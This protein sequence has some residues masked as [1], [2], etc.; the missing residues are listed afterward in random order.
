MIIFTFI[1]LAFWLWPVAVVPAGLSPAPASPAAPVPPLPYFSLPPA[2]SLCG[3]PVP[4]DDPL[5]AEDF[6]REFTI[7]VWSRAQT[8]LWIK[9]AA[10]Y[11]PH[12][13][14]KLRERK[15]PDDLKYVALIESDLLP[16]A[17]SSAGAQGI[18]QF[19]KPAAQRFTLK[20]EGR[21]DE[22]LDFIAATDAALQYLT[23]LHRQFGDWALAIAAYNCGEGRVQQALK[24]QGVRS[25][26]RLSLPEETERYVP[27]LLAAKIVLGDPGRYGYDIPPDQL[28][29][30]LK[31]DQVEFVLDRELHLRFV[32][33]ACGSY[34]KALRRLN[35]QLQDVKLA[36]GAY[37]LNVPAGA[38]PRFYEVYLQGRLVPP[39]P[40][41]EGGSPR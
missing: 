39:P 16:R 29:D 41:L 31:P 4:L 3:E 37:R 30:P 24:D 22:R 9:R 26:Y 15:L 20:T 2:L 6:D 33:E 38:A 1:A 21:I 40:A 12:V 23:V 13:E 14:Q 35:P 18:W 5:V 11:F 8:T 27:R 32:A 36:P 17:R 7:V 10:R 28:Y 19:M 34:F 25:Y